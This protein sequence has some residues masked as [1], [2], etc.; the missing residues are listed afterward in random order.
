MTNSIKFGCLLLLSLLSCQVS[1]VNWTDFLRR[2]TGAARPYLFAV[3]D[4][5]SKDIYRPNRITHILASSA[6]FSHPPVSRGFSLSI[7]S[8]PHRYGNHFPP[9]TRR[10]LERMENLPG[11]GHEHDDIQIE[12][13]GGAIG[14]TKYG[15]YVREEHRRTLTYESIADIALLNFIQPDARSRLPKNTRF[16]DTS[17]HLNFRHHSDM[18]DMPTH[19]YLRLPRGNPIAWTM[20]F[21]HKEQPV[22]EISHHSV[23]PELQS[24]MEFDN[25]TLHHFLDSERNEARD[26]MPYSFVL[27]V[28]DEVRIVQSENVPGMSVM[29]VNGMHI[30][31]WSQGFRYSIALI[32]M[33]LAFELKFFTPDVENEYKLFMKK[34]G[35]KYDDGAS[36]GGSSVTVNSL[37]DFNQ[38]PFPL[39][40][41]EM[42]HPGKASAETGKKTGL[43]FSLSSLTFKENYFSNDQLNVSTLFFIIW[44]FQQSKQ[45]P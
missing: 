10:Q 1:A 33:D 17:R 28:N 9:I 35:D 6:D 34:P 26:S 5:P 14:Q 7:F 29:V 43:P 41:W 39:T 36:G 24:L 11:T 18:G 23:A 2:I 37:F 31:I 16:H 25:Y 38:T 40:T 4:I 21:S 3:V 32:P 15:R 27:S 22:H 8:L 12:V 20:D 13:N 44:W 19:V 30:P 45:W 42:K